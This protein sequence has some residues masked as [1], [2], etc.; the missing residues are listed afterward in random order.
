MHISIPEA[1]LGI[2]KTEGKAK[3]GKGILGAALKPQVGPGQNTGG[4]PGAKPSETD[5]CLHIRR[6]S[7]ELR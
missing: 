3:E 5:E 6:V 7:F 2:S 4:G 1:D